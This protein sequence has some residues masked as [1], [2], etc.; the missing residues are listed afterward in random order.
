MWYCVLRRREWYDLAFFN[1]WATDPEQH[2][3]VFI[4]TLRDDLYKVVEE[5]QLDTFTYISSKVMGETVRIIKSKPNVVF[6]KRHIYFF[7]TFN[8]SAL[9]A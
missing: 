6:D 1:E 4:V 5:Y 8:F 2:A 3:L 9:N 7:Q